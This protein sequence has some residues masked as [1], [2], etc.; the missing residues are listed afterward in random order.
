MPISSLIVR[1]S[2]ADAFR[3]ACALR[4]N[5]AVTSCEVRGPDLLVI[6]ETGA[7]SDDEA[8]FKAFDQVAGVRAVELIYHNFEGLEEEEPCP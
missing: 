2:E 6:T 8:L 3:I 7:T 1:T 5:E 4:A